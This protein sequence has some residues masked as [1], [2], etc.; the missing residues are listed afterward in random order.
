MLFLVHL[1]TLFPGIVQL[2]YY[3]EDEKNVL[4]LL[5][6]ASGG[7]LFS[8]VRPRVRSVEEL[9]KAKQM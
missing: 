6:Y 2:H 3:F 4:L 9:A 5:E 8:Y 7:A 1:G